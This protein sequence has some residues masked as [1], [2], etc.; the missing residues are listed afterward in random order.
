[1]K[2]IELE[3]KLKLRKDEQQRAKKARDAKKRK[4][5]LVCEEHPE[6][7]TALNVREKVGRP[8]IEDD[9]PMLLK[10]IVDIAMY[11]SASHEKRKSSIEQSKHWMS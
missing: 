6:L 10:S 3:K 5:D 8:R 9:Q 11:G 7:R 1:M 4:L 2:K